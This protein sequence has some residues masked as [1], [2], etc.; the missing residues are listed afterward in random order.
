MPRGLSLR[1][2]LDKAT[3]EKLYL[4]AGLSTVVIAPRYGSNSSAVLRLMNEYEIARRSR[5]AGK[6]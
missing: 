1:D 6:T 4:D 2:R 5:G 3:L